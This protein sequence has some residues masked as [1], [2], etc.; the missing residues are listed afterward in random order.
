MKT[1]SLGEESIQ[2]LWK[3]VAYVEA[4]STVQWP[5]LGIG[6]SSSCDNEV[7]LRKKIT[8][9]QSDYRRHF[10]NNQLLFFLFKAQLCLVRH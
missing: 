2:A 3:S 10:F 5:D 1:E 6:V 8:S 4:F 9:Y 7:T